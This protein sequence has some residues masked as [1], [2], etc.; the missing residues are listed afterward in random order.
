MGVSPQVF[1]H[2]A[3]FLVVVSVR[4]LH[5][6][7]EECHSLLEIG[8]CL[9][10]QEQKLGRRGA[11]VLR[12][13]FIQKFGFLWFTTYMCYADGYDATPSM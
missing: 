6:C 9:L 7:Y 3:E 11:K 8:L 12:I 5:P 10:G 1:K 13:C 2:S 4:I